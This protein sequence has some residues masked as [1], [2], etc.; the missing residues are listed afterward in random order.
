MTHFVHKHC[1]ISWN[2]IPLKL[3]CYPRVTHVIINKLNQNVFISIQNLGCFESLLDQW[4]VER[5]TVHKD[6]TN[7]KIVLLWAVQF[8]YLKLSGK[9][10][11]NHCLLV[12]VL[13]NK[14][15]VTYRWSRLSPSVTFCNAISCTLRN[16]RI[17][18]LEF[19]IW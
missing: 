8:I 1:H 18:P 9:G 2:S 19:K 17:V 5:R 12:L 16:T 13:N 14:E 4:F 3:L 7:T 10:T 11:S 15:C 6:Q